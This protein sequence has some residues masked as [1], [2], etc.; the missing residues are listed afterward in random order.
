MP[1]CKALDIEINKVGSCPQGSPSEEG[2][3]TQRD[4]VIEKMQ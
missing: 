2:T 1:I 4:H 3:E